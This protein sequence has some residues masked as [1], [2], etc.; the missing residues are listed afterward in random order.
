MAILAAMPASSSPRGR[1]AGRPRR[2]TREEILNTAESLWQ[3]RGYNAFSYHH[4]A[5]QLGIRNA[6]IHYHF[7]GKEDLGVELIRRYRD[8]FARWFASVDTEAS[9]AVRMNCY[10]GLYLDFLADECKVCPSGILGAE[11]MSIPEEMR[12]EAQLLMRQI[13]EWLMAVLALGQ[14]QESLGFEGDAETKALQIGASLQGGLQIARIAGEHRFY[15]ILNRIRSDLGMPIPAQ[16][17]VD[18]AD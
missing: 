3:H 10:F 2:D 1:R 18:Q 12:A 9:A 16:I 4:I 17:G 8:R 5:V 13:H 11:F 7:P 15:Q 6:A 14:E